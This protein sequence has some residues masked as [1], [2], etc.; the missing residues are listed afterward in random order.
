MG[1]RDTIFQDLLDVLASIVEDELVA[2]GMVEQEACNV[3]DFVVEGDIAV[4]LSVVLLDFG[5]SEFSESFGSHLAVLSRDPKR[6]TEMK[7]RR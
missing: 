2:A 4:P 1:V 3:V 6:R 5:A 7:W